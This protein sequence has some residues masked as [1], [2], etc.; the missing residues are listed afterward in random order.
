MVKVKFNPLDDATCRRGGWG[1]TIR[2]V[3]RGFNNLHY[4]G[5]REYRINMAY[6]QCEYEASSWINAVKTE[7]KIF[8]KH[9][10]KSVSPFF[11]WGPV[12]L[13]VHYTS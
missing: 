6:L 1:Y 7:H 12:N 9:I 2:T 11:A 8:W 13:V 4:L 5:N 3:R 10:A